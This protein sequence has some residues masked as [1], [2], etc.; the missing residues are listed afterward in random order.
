M[1][2]SNVRPVVSN[3]RPA[4][5]SNAPAPKPVAPT[6]VPVKAQAGGQSGFGGLLK[7]LFLDG[8][9]SLSGLLSIGND[10]KELRT[11][12]ENKTAH[13]VEVAGDVLNILSW[14]TAFIPGFG[15]AIAGAANLLGMAVKVTGE[16]MA[17]KK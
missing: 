10:M 1:Q 12:A 8:W 7:A 13:A 5:V 14:P 17:G 3:I 9:G 2:V 11:D 4:V 15:P 16:M 6:N